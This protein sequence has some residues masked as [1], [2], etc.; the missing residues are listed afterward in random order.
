V[1]GLVRAAL[2]DVW[3]VQDLE[4]A[5]R[6][7]SGGWRGRL[8]TLSGEV[9]TGDGL[10]AAR[11]DGSASPLGRAQEIASLR[12]SLEELDREEEDLRRRAEA[13]EAEREV[14]RARWEQA[15]RR[16]E[17]LGARLQEVREELT[18]VDARKLALPAAVQ[19]AALELSQVRAQLVELHDQDSRWAA[20]LERLQAELVQAR[21]SLEAARRRQQEAEV[22]AGHLAEQVAGLR[23]REVEVRALRDAAASRLQD[24]GRRWEAAKAEEAR[25]QAEEASAAEEL[26]RLQQAEAEAL[27]RAGEARAQLE[28]LR[29]EVDQAAAD[30]GA[31]ESEV[32]GLQPRAEAAQQAARAAEEELHRLELRAAQ[33]AAELAA[34]ERRLR[35]AGGGDPESLEKHAPERLDRDGLVGEVESLRARLAA[36]GPVNLQAEEEYREV[37]ARCEELSL[38]AQDVEEAS[39]LACELA[40][41]LEAV[42]RQRFRQTFEEVDRHFQ[43]CFRRLFGGGRAWLERVTTEDGEEGVEVAAQPPG[44][45]VRSLAALSGGERVLVA[46]ALVFAL[47]RTHPSP[48]C[49][50][51]EIEAALDEANT[52]RVVD[53]LRELAR[54]SQVVIITHNKATMEAA[55]VLYGVT[56]QEPGVSSVVSMRIARRNPEAAAVG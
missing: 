19:D 22:R 3:V 2:Q 27:R 36:F 30:R 6:L 45:K 9:L 37:Q 41:R 18:R 12:R 25:L 11:R 49:V 56:T 4:A 39:A 51:D 23:V 15:R 7:R 33:A 42:L 50:F 13:L 55:D 5:L 40:S 38:H 46:L 29:A 54:R 26:D 43:D 35:E 44:K 31:A 34:V 17:E 10:L 21:A 52:R 24:A 1:H 47:L 28:R 32:A 48:F 14:L 16:A 8:V 53:L 20:D